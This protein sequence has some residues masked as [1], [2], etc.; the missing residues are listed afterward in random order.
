MIAH[1]YG[2]DLGLPDLYD[3]IG[4]STDTDVGWW[5]LMSTG[6]HS[7]RLFQ[8][9]PT[10]MGAWSKYVLG[11]IEPEVLEYGSKRAKLTLGQG[12]RPPKGTES[13]VRDQPA[14]QAGGGRRAA[15][16]RAG[17]V[18]LQRP[19]LGRRPADPQH[20]RARGQRRPVLE[21]ERLH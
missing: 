19:E 11:W 20:R 10:H 1:E 18:E 13:A 15:L 3:S 14:G 2:H 9:L 8:T 6:S 16:R 21:L 7:G 17:L 12:S 4:P 5:D